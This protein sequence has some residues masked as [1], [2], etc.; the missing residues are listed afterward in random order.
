VPRRGAGRVRGRFLP[1]MVATRD[2][3]GTVSWISGH[4]VEE[5]R[6]NSAGGGEEAGDPRRIVQVEGKGKAWR[7]GVELKMRGNRQGTFGWVLLKAAGG[8]TVSPRRSRRD[9]R[10]DCERGGR[11][12]ILLERS[13]SP[14]GNARIVWTIR[15][16]WFLDHGEPGQAVEPRGL[17][18]PQ[19]KCFRSGLM[20]HNDP[21]KVER[22][23]V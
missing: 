22:D 2:V 6:A 4:C 1:G 8:R 21:S 5:L 12:P 18:D 19:P 10:N 15:Y 14:E 17:G 13:K 11:L 20:E 7:C 23:S 9:G 16:R 3:A